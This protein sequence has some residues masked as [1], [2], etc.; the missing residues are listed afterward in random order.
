MIEM[1]TPMAAFD[2]VSARD[3]SHDDVTN[4]SANDAMTKHRN[5]P[6]YGTLLGAVDTN[7][8]MTVAELETI[9]PRLRI[10]RIGDAEKLH[11]IGQVDW[12]HRS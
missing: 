11:A 2:E 1:G 6:N 12:D 3:E 4:P 9:N 10:I 7:L 8:V 5:N